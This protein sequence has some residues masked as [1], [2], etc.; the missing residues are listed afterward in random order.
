MSLV[1]KFIITIEMVLLAFVWYYDPRP[2]KSDESFT[3][4]VDWFEKRFN[5][6]IT[7]LPITFTDMED[8]IAVAAC[9]VYSNNKREIKVDLKYWNTLSHIKRFNLIWHELG[10]C[11]LDF[12]HH[13][14]LLP[15]NC[16]E[17]MM[18][19]F[20]INDACL[21]KHIEHYIINLGIGQKQ[22]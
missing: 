6:K 9:F 15:D 2:S 4:Y 21:R 7:D 18:N 17:S 5:T 22:K 1:F 10:H 3:E 20:V 19:S 8:K 14:G 12:E 13:D 16:P 11:H